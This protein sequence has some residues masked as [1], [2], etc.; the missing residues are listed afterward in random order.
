MKDIYYKTRIGTLIR[1][2]FH[3]LWN[4]LVPDRI[5]VSLK[6]KNTFG[7][8]PRLHPPVT[9]NE[10]IIWLKLYE[11]TPLHTKC[12]DKFA[13]REYI[14]E[15]IG[16]KYLVPLFFHTKNPEDINPDNISEIPCIIKTNHDSGGGVF[17]R[18]KETHDWKDTRSYLKW[19]LSKNYYYS[20]KEWQY[21]NIKPRIIVEKLLEDSNGNIPFDY[22]LHCFNGM[23]NMV[24]VDFGR[25]TENHHRNWYSPNWE[26]EPYKWSSEKADGKL[27]DPSPEDIEKPVSLNKMIQLSEVLAKDFNYVRVDWYD[28]EGELY[29]GELT[30]HHDGGYRPIMPEKW[31]K[32]LGEKLVIP[33][34]IN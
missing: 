33:Q 26:R 17:V 31:D 28:L 34:L 25:G 2:I 29:F 32:I 16:S 6:Y 15:K 18:D 8:K 5:H 13:V 30:F 4:N 20:S 1:N 27:T 12:T 19:R 7:K 22:K 11:R 3:Y 21:K 10:K 9:L 14:K 24:Q 23:V